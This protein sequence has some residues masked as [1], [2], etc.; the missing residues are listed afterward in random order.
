[1]NH[2][3]EIPLG[4]PALHQQFSMQNL[5]DE[6]LDGDAD[7]EDGGMLSTSLEGSSAYLPWGGT[8][9][10]YRFPREESTL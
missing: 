2:H 3:Q 9:S 10:T 7:L 1:L 4:P 6:D 8:A 5:E